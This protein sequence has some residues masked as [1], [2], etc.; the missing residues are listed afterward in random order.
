MT[1]CLLPQ[2]LVARLRPD[3]E[4]CPDEVTVV[5]EQRT[6][7]RRRDGDR[8]ADDGR[9]R[10]PLSTL[11]ERRHI[12]NAAGRRVGERRATL[13]PVAAPSNLTRRARAESDRLLFV[14]PLEPDRDHMDETESA[15]LVT[16]L[17]SG[18]AGA[19]IGLY[20]LHFERVYTYLRIMLGANAVEQAVERTFVALAEGLADYQLG[21]Q[22]FRSHVLACATQQLICNGDLRVQRE[23][24]GPAEPTCATPAIH[25][26]TDSDL[27]AVLRTLPVEYRQVLVLRYRSN[28]G[29]HE[30][31]IV[32]GCS[33]ETVGRLQE[34][35]LAVLRR[36]LAAVE[37]RLTEPTRG[38]QVPMR[39][40][41]RQAPVLRARRFVLER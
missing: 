10:T 9:A 17:Q 5:V 24:D 1:Y 37:Q 26:L 29:L 13:I 15:R 31:G 20:E 33:H 32:M 25:A 3:L 22:S 14:E 35:A 28:L 38:L 6:F 40:V 7:D 4:R 27:L 12:R 11:L 19:L 2:Q 36:R 23:P 41:F 21:R 16:R 30:T 8:R 34:H 18:D 39:A